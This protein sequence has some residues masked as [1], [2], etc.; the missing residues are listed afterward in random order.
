LEREASTQEEICLALEKKG[1]EVNQSK[2]S[3]LLRKIG[4]IKIKN[5]QNQAAYSLPREPPPPSAQ[6]PLKDLV[7]DISFNETLIVI[8][9]SPGSASMVARILDYYQVASEILGTLA[10]DDT[11]FVAPRSI[12]DLPRLAEKI[13]TLLRG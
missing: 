11:I 2:I 5:I 1:F 6:T 8:S 7:L 10:G 12:K 3:R 13:K 9:T 4:A